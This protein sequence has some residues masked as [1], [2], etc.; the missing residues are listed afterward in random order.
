MI[1][2]YDT[3]AVPRR[4]VILLTDLCEGILAFGQVLQMASDSMRLLLR[5]LL[6]LILRLLVGGLLT[7]FSH[8]LLCG[9]WSRRHGDGHE[10]RVGVGF[11]TRYFVRY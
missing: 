5:A 6:L 9:A 8:L 1:H 7:E 10:G 2:V 3:T 11:Y 4:S